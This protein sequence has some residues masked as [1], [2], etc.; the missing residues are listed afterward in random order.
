MLGKELKKKPNILCENLCVTLC[1]LWLALWWK[2]KNLYHRGHREH[3]EKTQRTTLRSERME[4]PGRV[5]LPTLQFRQ[6]DATLVPGIGDGVVR[7]TLSDRASS[8]S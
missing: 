7:M 3:R 4:A 5:E 8:R 6:W 2:N 1:P